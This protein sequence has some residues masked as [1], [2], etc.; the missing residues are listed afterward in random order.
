VPQLAIGLQKS[1]G[2]ISVWC[3]M[4]DRRNAL[5]V[6]IAILSLTA[7]TIIGANVA[8]VSIEWLMV[9]IGAGLAAVPAVVALVRRHLD[10][11]EPVHLFAGSYGVLFVIRPIYDLST[12]GGLPLWIGL[13]ITSG[14]LQA[15]LAAALGMA[16]FYFG[17]YGSSGTRLAR[18]V[19][20][21]RFD[22]SKPTLIGLATAGMISAVFLFSLYVSTTGG[23]GS[24]GTL[25]NGRNAI[26]SPLWSSTGYLSSAPLWMASF[27]ILLLAVT[28]RWASLQGAAAA[29][30]LTA[31]QIVTIGNG[32]RS[33]FLP[34][35]GCVIILWYFRRRRRPSIV[36]IAIALPLVFVFGITLPRDF[37]VP[38]DRQQSLFG[39][40][41]SD[42]ASPQADLD[43]FFRSAETG[44]VDDLSLEIQAIPSSVPYALGLTYAGDLTRPIPR[45]L[46]PDKPHEE[47]VQL[48]EAIWP[49][50]AQFT[51]FTFSAFGE[52]YLNFSYVGVIVVLA[53]FGVVWKSFYIWF[54]KGED[55]PAV[56]A[57]FAASLP[58]MV[59]Y[60]RGGIGT[61]Y[62]RQL[63]LLVPMVV[64]IVVSRRRSRA[65]ASVPALPQVAPRGV[66]LPPAAQRHS[67]QK[68]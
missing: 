19:P 25:I 17:Y 30:M 23:I 24:L 50:L 6:I 39:Q 37:R 12:P 13:D 52:P 55:A 45:P 29:L 64:A 2:G 57:I 43:V 51:T 53:L 36:A 54:R 56:Q 40:A 59:V 27:G 46:W 11:F 35:V 28:P 1:N 9:V 22:L 58:F 34:V 18:L 26:S 68:T 65:G 14:Y 15:L 8:M 48:T 7:A 42:L 5:L 31:S 33:W 10:V 44:M 61:D 21:P 32:S 60:M 16:A 47:D 67:G 66:H 41:L 20:V 4:M 63:I 62:H 38:T 49:S 3:P